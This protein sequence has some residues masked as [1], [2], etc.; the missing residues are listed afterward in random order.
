MIP[1]TTPFQQHGTAKLEDKINHPSHY[2]WHPVAECKDIAGE[3]N[4]NLGTA[5]AYIWRCGLK[6][7]DTEVE[8]LRKA[9]KHLEFECARLEGSAQPRKQRQSPATS[10]T[11]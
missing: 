10:K 1:C 7:P 9:I 6:N 11:P 8:D 5:I 4:Y 3:F 2:G